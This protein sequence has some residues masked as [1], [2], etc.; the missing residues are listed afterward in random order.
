MTDTGHLV[1]R[2]EAEAQRDH[3]RAYL[4]GL[5][6]GFWLSLFIFTVVAVVWLIVS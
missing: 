2:T 4:L 6:A 3:N 1:I 5:A